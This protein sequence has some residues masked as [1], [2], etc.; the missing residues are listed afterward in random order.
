M[1]VSGNTI[2]AER[3]PTFCCCNKHDNDNFIRPIIIKSLILI[4]DR[5]PG[6]WGG[7]YPKHPPPQ[8]KNTKK[9]DNIRRSVE[10]LFKKNITKIY[11]YCSFLLACV[12]FRE[13]CCCCFPDVFLWP[14]TL[15]QYCN[16][17][18]AMTMIQH[19]LKWRGEG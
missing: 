3:S 1:L 18:H 13:I 11:F 5:N 14:W 12:V 2:Y 9:F 10:F 4:T 16:R 8:K 7:A 17:V 19:S 15:L 6:E